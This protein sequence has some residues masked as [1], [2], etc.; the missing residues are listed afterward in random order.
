VVVNDGRPGVYDL[1]GNGR[2]WTSK[3][4]TTDG[5]QTVAVLGGWSYA[6]AVRA[7]GGK[8]DLFQSQFPEHASPFTS[9]RVVIELP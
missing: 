1:D 2:E 3:N 8:S 9:F 7:P 6:S 4:E 5:G